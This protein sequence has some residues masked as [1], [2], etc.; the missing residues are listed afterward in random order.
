MEQKNGIWRMLSAGA[1]SGGCWGIIEAVWRLAGSANGTYD[2]LFWSYCFY[3]FL[4]ALIG[5]LLYPLDRFLGRERSESLRWS[6]CFCVVFFGLS[7]W[8]IELWYGILFLI[9]CIS[10][11]GE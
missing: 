5:V 6:T 7:I 3:V 10:E 11:Q 8:V 2:A 9:P 1:L 4:G